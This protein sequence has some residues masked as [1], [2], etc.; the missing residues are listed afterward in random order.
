MTTSKQYYFRA[1]VD[2]VYHAFYF[3]TQDTKEARS[4]ASEI[5]KMLSNATQKPVNY[6]LADTI[7]QKHII[8][9]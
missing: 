3:N 4:I 9:F 6:E 7:E 2:G 8:E 1:N 5:A